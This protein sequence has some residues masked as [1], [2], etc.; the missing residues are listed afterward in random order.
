[1]II[2]QIFVDIGKGK[3]YLDNPIYKKC[4]A[5]NQKLHPNFRHKIWNEKML[6]NLVKKH[7]P[8]YLEFWNEFPHP[9]W[10]IDFGRYMLLHYEG[11][12]YIDMDDVITEPIILDRDIVTTFTRDNGKTEFGNNIIHFQD[13]NIYR[14]LMNFCLERK[15][16]C[17]MPPNWKQ[18]RFFYIVGQRVFDYFVKHKLKYPLQKAIQFNTYDTN[19]WLF[20]F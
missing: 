15:K 17:K 11:G 5:Q 1:M 19:S 14:Q 20:I 12:I 10:K 7:Y 13:R 9:F 16:T 2:H 4:V 3:T 8:E 18:R 6:D